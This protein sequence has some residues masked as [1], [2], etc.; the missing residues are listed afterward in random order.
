MSLGQRIVS[1]CLLCQPQRWLSARMKVFFS[2]IRSLHFC[3]LEARWQTMCKANAK[4]LFP[5]T[6]IAH[7]RKC[8]HLIYLKRRTSFEHLASLCVCCSLLEFK[9]W[10]QAN[11]DG[12]AGSGVGSTRQLF[13]SACWRRHVH[14]ASDNLGSAGLAVHREGVLLEQ[15]S[16]SCSPFKSLKRQR[17]SNV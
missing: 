16:A 12:T 7:S 13:G 17:S 2:D 10:A 1:S 11:P 4:Y 6:H 14:F 9:Q 5:P 15:R 8:P 3:L